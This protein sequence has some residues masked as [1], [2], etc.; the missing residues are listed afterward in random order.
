LTKPLLAPAKLQRTDALT[1]ASVGRGQSMLKAGAPTDILAEIGIAGK[2]R[3]AGA[4]SS[5][6]GLTVAR[7]AAT[8]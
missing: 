8:S 6:E 2:R 3:E 1:K 5:I 4:K 7:V